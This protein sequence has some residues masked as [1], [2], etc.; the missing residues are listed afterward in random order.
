MT[1]P[2]NEKTVHTREPCPYCKATGVYKY[3][4]KK[5]GEETLMVFHPNR[6]LE[7]QIFAIVDEVTY[8]ELKDKE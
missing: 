6:P 8:H 3:R 1:V 4:L 2:V 7:P 5:I